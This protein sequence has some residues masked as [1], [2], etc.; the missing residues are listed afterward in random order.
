MAFHCFVIKNENFIKNLVNCDVIFFLH[1]MCVLTTN[2]NTFRIN[3][4]IVVEI[5]VNFRLQP[6]T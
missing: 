6:D 5:L 1:F 2:Q 3:L 4:G